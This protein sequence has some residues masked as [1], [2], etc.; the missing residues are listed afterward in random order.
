MNEFDFDPLELSAEEYAPP[1]AF[2]A[3]G[4]VP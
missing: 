3:G 2:G 1:G 4:Y